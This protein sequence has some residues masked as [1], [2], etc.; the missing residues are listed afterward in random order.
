M[1]APVDV[2]P[3]QVVPLM[4]TALHTVRAS[5]AA[6]Q[7]VAATKVRG[8]NAKNALVAAVANCCPETCESNTF[9]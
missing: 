1:L 5:Q 7:S 3:V 9:V 6:K 8:P 4:N 2:S